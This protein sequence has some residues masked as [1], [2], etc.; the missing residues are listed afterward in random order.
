MFYSG[1]IIAMGLLIAPSQAQENITFNKS[2]VC[3]KYENT[4]NNFSNPAFSSLKIK[5]D[6]YDISNALFDYYKVKNRADCFSNCN[7]N[8]YY[9]SH[10]FI[11]DRENFP[12]WTS[13][14]I[15]SDGK[16][17]PNSSSGAKTVSGLYMDNHTTGGKSIYLTS[18]NSANYHYAMYSHEIAHYWFDK[19]CFNLGSNNEY[20]AN[21]FHLYF[22][23]NYR[24][25]IKNS[26]YRR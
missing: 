8:V 14:T 12:Y 6:F 21:K 10:N 16:Y 19:K 23:S 25:L 9:T 13:G 11:N 2:Y 18:L 4:I 24:H 7:L 26:L 15:N 3:F 1:V 17:V 22:M 20:E 5:S